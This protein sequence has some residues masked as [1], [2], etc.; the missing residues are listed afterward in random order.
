VI[1][2]NPSGVIPSIYLITPPYICAGTN[3][4]PATRIQATMLK[5]PLGLTK[6]AQ[7]TYG[8]TFSVSLMEMS[9][10]A[11]SYASNQNI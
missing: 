8:G 6:D 7:D 2:P 9:S 11:W 10:R 4:N 5:A 1:D 3:G